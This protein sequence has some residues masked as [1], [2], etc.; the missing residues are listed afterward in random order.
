M[1]KRGAPMSQIDLTG[2]GPEAS[3]PHIDLTQSDDEAAPQQADASQIDLTLSDDEAPAPPARDA[4]LQQVRA[5]AAEAFKRS[6]TA[7]SPNAAPSGAWRA[8]GDERDCDCERLVGRRVFKNFSAACAHYQFPGSHQVGSYGPKG[9]GIVRTYSNATPGKDVVLDGGN[10]FLY[11][12]KD[13][14]V[15]AQFRVNLERR[16]DVRVFRKVSSG[17]VELGLF[18]VEGFVPAGP[19]D[20]VGQFG[21]EFVRM[22]RADAASQP[23]AAAPLEAARPRKRARK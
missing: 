4:A 20:Q 22:V 5:E 10:L 16:R 13:E 8:Q 6:R 18:R 2:D 23:R 12:L 3:A 19:G 15:R 1:A 11:R 14:A 17:V 7:A 21:R 9:Q